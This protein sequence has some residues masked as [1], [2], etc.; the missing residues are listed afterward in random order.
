[1]FAATMFFAPTVTSVRAATT[2]VCISGLPWAVAGWAPMAF[3]GVEVNRLG[4]SSTSSA[5]AGGGA[6]YRRLSTDSIEL[7][8]AIPS[9]SILHL[10]HGPV[11]EDGADAPNG[12]TGELAGLYLGVLNVYTT[13]PQFVGTFIS[14]IVFSILEPGTSPE[15]HEGEAGGGGGG[16]EKQ[17]GV[18]AI[19]VCLFI[20]ACCAVVAAYATRRMKFMD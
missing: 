19:A 4:L 7:E 17:E 9:R 16:G 18:N 5:A 14:M 10:N 2:L 11:A 1:M 13:L 12:S 6:S 15:L 8:E 3:L 20:G